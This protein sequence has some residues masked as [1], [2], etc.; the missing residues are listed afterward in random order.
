MKMMGIAGL[1]ICVIC[2]F[3]AYERYQSNAS[4]IEAMRSMQQ[5]TGLGEM[6]GGFQ[7]EAG[8]P[9]ATKYALFFALLSGVGGALLLAKSKE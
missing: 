7:L 2:L 5:S 4:N 8:T 6:M 3:V 9:A 1:V